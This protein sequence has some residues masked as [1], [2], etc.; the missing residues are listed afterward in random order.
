MVKLKE[1]SAEKIKEMSLIDLC[2]AYMVEEGIE[3]L[4]IYDFLDY[5]KPLRNVDEEE[6]T[7]QAAYFYTDLNLDG[8]FVCVEDGSWKLRD[9]LFVEDIKN[10]VEPSVQKFE[11]DEED[12]D[13]LGDEDQDDIHD[14]VDDLIEDEDMEESEDVYDF[15]NDGIVSKFNISAE[16]EEF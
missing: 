10:F 11:I 3:K 6:F 14:A 1:L 9:S 12:M 7:A 16:E 2:F 8:R 15:D 5:I 13:E 4:N